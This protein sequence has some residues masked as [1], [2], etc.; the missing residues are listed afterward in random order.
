MFKEQ[1][2]GQITFGHTGDLGVLTDLMADNVRPKVAIFGGGGQLGVL[3]GGACRPIAE[4]NLLPKFNHFYAD[5]TGGGVAYFAKIYQLCM[6]GP[7]TDELL[8]TYHQDNIQNGLINLFRFWNVIKL[9]PLERVL[10]SKDTGFEPVR[11]SKPD[12]WV[13]VTDR[14]GI[15]QQI[16]L[17]YVS[18]PMSL[19]MDAMAV[20][21]LTNRSRD[22][23]RFYHDGSFDRPLRLR[24]LATENPNQDLLVFLAT[25][26]EAT[27]DT[28][29]KPLSAKARALL[30]VTGRIFEQ[31][32]LRN[33]RYVGAFMSYRQRY[34]R[35]LAFLADPDLWPEN[36]R[37]L[38]FHPTDLAGHNEFCMHGPVLKEGCETATDYVSG[39]IKSLEQPG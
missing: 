2:R 22:A 26:V 36:F 6:K 14:N 13:N 24:T 23:S 20:P 38:A 9:A 30:E 21:L 37:M 25:P 7:Q 29:A 39:L 10:R 34:Y 28:A 27:S 16:N 1:P 33:F 11:Y 18:D 31:P 8:A 15:N 5:S 32:W 19:V 4:A 35:E 17:R 12:L 3:E